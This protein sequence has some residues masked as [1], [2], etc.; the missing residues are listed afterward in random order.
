MNFEVLIEAI[1]ELGGVTLNS[2]NFT[3]VS[4]EEL[5]VLTA[6]VSRENDLY[7]SCVPLAEG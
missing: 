7:I 5:K 1:D 2:I 4:L 3:K 6:I